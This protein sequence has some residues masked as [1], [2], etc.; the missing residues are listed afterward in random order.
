VSK[1]KSLSTS[2]RFEVFKRDGFRCIYCG[3]T[4][5]QSALRVD[6][7]EPV[8]KGGTDEPSN[9]VTSCFTCNAGKAARRLDE[10]RLAVGNPA[11]A[12]EHAEQIRAYLE[13]QREVDAARREVA[14]DL[15]N[16]W[17]EILGP[18]SQ[19]MFDRLPKL[20][21]EWP[22]DLLR[23]AMVITACKLGRMDEYDYSDAVRQ[24]RYFHGILRKWREEAP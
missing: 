6:H 9:L 16:L 22:H 23:E 15:S 20:G 8:A 24:Q 3:S 2:L 19:E 7:V 1:R 21:S 10:H 5:V 13:A 17:E 18:M 11:I 14:L 4:P 12:K